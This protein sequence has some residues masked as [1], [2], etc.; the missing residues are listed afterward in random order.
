MSSSLLE[1]CTDHTRASEPLGVI[2]AA[3]LEEARRDPKVIAL[4]AEADSYLAEL[5][6]HGRNL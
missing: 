1:N 6:R 3:D 2:A 5:E 4:L